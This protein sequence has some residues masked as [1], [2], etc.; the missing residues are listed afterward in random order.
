[1]QRIDTVPAIGAASDNPHSDVEPAEITS[2]MLMITLLL[3]TGARHAFKLDDKY[4]KKRNVTVEEDN[5]IN[6]SV[7]TLKE[8]IWRDWRGGELALLK[9]RLRGN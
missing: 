8:L 1:M 3:N 4:L 9:H 7:Y 5:P 2:T 6:L